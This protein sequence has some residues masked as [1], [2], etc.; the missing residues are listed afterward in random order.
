MPPRSKSFEFPTDLVELQHAWDAA[1][2]ALRAAHDDL[3][4]LAADWPEG[5]EER[6]AAAQE[7][8]RRIGEEMR[9]HP[10]WAGVPRED[11]VAA[12]TALKYA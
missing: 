5:A 7:E 8:I 11:L 9:V 6:V 1:W 3:P 2:R 12:R 10:W 4:A